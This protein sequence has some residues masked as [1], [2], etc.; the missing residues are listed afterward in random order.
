MNLSQPDCNVT[1]KFKTRQCTTATGVWTDIAIIGWTVHG[2]CG[3]F[4]SKTYF[5]HNFSGLKEYVIL[6]LLSDFRFTQGIEACPDSRILANVYSA[7]CGV[8]VCCEYTVDP[9]SAVCETGWNG[10]PPHYGTA[11]TKVKSCKWQ[12]CGTTCCRRT[13]SVCLKS[14]PSG[15]NIRD[16]QLLGKEKLGPCSGESQYAKPCEHGC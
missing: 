10:P 7:A 11:P 1:V 14:I 12:S 16:I 5:H 2:G 6:G 3:G 15:N 8:W 9:A 4:D 13:Y